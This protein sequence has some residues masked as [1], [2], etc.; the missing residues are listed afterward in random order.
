MSEMKINPSPYGRLLLLLPPMK[1]SCRSSWVSWAS[2]VVG[3]KMKGWREKGKGKKEKSLICW[4]P[5]RWEGSSLEDISW[6]VLQLDKYLALVVYVRHFLQLHY[7]L[8]LRWD[9]GTILCWTYSSRKILHDSGAC[10]A[11]AWNISYVWKEIVTTYFVKSP[12]LRSQKRHSCTHFL[13][14]LSKRK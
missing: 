9:M 10:A 3:R 8:K 4:K 2:E 1:G 11:T 6:E 7:A 5:L 14:G 12:L 13:W